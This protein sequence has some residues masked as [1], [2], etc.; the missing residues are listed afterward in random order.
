MANLDI[1]SKIKLKSGWEIP[2]L[3]YGMYIDLLVEN[4]GSEHQNDIKAVFYT[5]R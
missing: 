4:H 2:R 3:G 1:N 5:S